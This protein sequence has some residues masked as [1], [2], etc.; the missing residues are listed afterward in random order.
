[1]MRL[2]PDGAMPDALPSRELLAEQAYLVARGVRR[3]SLADTAPDDVDLALLTL[4][5]E[6]ERH[7]EPTAIPLV[8]DHGVG[9][10]S[11]G[12]PDSRWALDQNYEAQGNRRIARLET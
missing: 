7:A 2:N 10:A 11:F 9:V 1:M 6:L 5:S 8:V 12:Y 4:A 3:L